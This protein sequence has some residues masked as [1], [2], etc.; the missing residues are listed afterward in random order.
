MD[1]MRYFV[2]VEDTNVANVFDLADFND[3]GYLQGYEYED[4]YHLDDFEDKVWFENIDD[5]WAYAE[6]INNAE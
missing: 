5:A 6:D 3:N 1:K 4:G 2:C